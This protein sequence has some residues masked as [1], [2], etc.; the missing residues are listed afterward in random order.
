MCGIVAALPV[1][2]DPAA[3]HAAAA[4]LTELAGGLPEPPWATGGPTA[5]D[6]HVTEKALLALAE[7]ME[8]LDAELSR[9]ELA[10]RLALDEPSRRAVGAACESLTAWAEDLDSRLDA[11]G[12]DAEI[13]EV[14]QSGLRRLGDVLHGL[15][16]D[17]VGVA[18]RARGLVAELA[19]PGAATSYL[20]VETVLDALNRL[21]VRGRD[22]AGVCVWVNL[23]PD[24]RGAVPAA[25][26]GRDDPLL[27][28]GSAMPTGSG[29]CFVYKRAAIVG[30]LG[31]NVAAL[32]QQLQQDAALHRLLALPSARVTVLAHTRWASVGRIS[33]ANAH[34]V[35]SRDPAGGSAGPFAVAVLNG[36]IDNYPALQARLDY[37]PSDLGISTDAKVIPLLLSRKVAAGAAPVDALC[38]AL[39]EFAGSMAIGAALDDGADGTLLLAV[40]GSGQGLYVGLAPAGFVVASEVYGLVASTRSFLRLEGGP[41]AGATR[42][43]TVIA[44]SR[45]GAGTL[46]GLDR[47]NGDGVPQPV[48]QAEVRLAEVTTRDLAL[49]SAQ[50][51]LQKEVFEAPA[52]FRKT[53]RG[54]VQQQES[55]PVVALP[56]SSLPAAVRRRLADGSIT[57]LIAIG[58]G[59]AAVACQGIAGMIRQSTGERLAVSAMPATEFSA[60]VL[61]P[62]MTDVC[63]VAVSQSGTTTDTNRAVD[64]AHARGAAVIAIVN[65]R[66]SDL[67]TKS[68]GVIYTS[69][70]RDVEMAVA[71]TKAF[72]A[73]AAAGCLLGVELA[74]VLGTLVPERNTVL[75]EALLE[76]P[77]RLRAL[78]A[79]EPQLAQAAAE[80]VTRYP[81]WA[82]LGSGQSRVAAE[83]IRIK[84]S[85]L[86]YKT[87]STDAVEDKKHI[88]LSA[89][90]LV[91]VCVAG[92]PV[93]QLSDLAKEV[94]IFA[95]HG[96]R[97]V[98][99]CDEGTEDLWPA[100][101]VIGIPAGHRDLA[102]I[103]T[104]AA[105]HLFAYHAARTIDA[106]ADAPRTALARLEAALDAGRH[107]AADLPLD[108]VTPVAEMLGRIGR[109]E[110]RGVLSSQTTLALAQLLLAPRVAAATDL[111]G[112]GSGPAE[113]AVA[114]RAALTQA[115]DELARSIDTV[116]HQAKTV[117]VGTSRDDADLYDNVVVRALEEA[118]LD[119]QFLTLA[120]L[121]VIRTH[122]ALIDQAAGVSRYRGTGDGAARTV[123]VLRRT[124]IAAELTSRADQPVPLAGSKRRVADLGVPRLLRG[125]FDGRVVLIVPELVGGS[126][127][128]LSVVHVRLRERAELET[129]VAAMATAG[130]R[131]AEVEAAV[132]ETVPGFTPDWLLGLA[133]EDVLLAPVDA[134]A[135]QVLAA[136]AAAT[137][138]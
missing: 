43:G 112:S 75:V 108:V 109:G 13:T 57:E 16:H 83:E 29:A 15:L 33:E 20:A 55:G 26:A 2:G 61:R 67:A 118:G 28:A 63:V 110:L 135:E 99:I 1:Y 77:D 136:R 124:G 58:Q 74:Q 78:H 37:R 21:E 56:E 34:P 103:L 94:D 62:D 73:Q 69:D 10:A 101:T 6:P 129:L 87:I 85:E 45:D 72:Y 60:W 117:T 126:A 89:E 88:D 44:L 137:S 50:H 138:G 128:H 92:S 105:G 93:N 19:A 23:A 130:D 116:K 70:G 127:A 102:W 39:G 84:L 35:D 30:G 114:A 97:P 76:M 49:G 104:T 7:R 4:R 8:A 98:V 3:D 81:Y 27:R 71:S 48:Q 9:P 132:T 113:P 12:W 32:R 95:A 59:T 106:A 31:D 122:A 53:L 125:R 96:N 22:S 11:A 80:V 91:L 42:H 54:R 25:V 46:A 24:E 79:L 133:T 111:S 52:S 82:V 17:R 18:E 90:S 51:Y 100:Q 86:C 131:L 65:R 119:R 40:K 123:Q 107:P 5:R 41:V 121:R 134:V 14:V 66:D 68:D 38:D 47:R 64:L 36:D 120:S 115:I